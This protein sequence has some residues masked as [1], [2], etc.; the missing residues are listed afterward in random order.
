MVG[1]P[2]QIDIREAIPED[3]VAIVELMLQA[4]G[5][6]LQFILDELEP[7][8]SAS[9]L[10]RHMITSIDSECSYRRCWVAVMPSGAHA[11]VVGMVN[12]FPA[13]LLCAQG[14]PSNLT[15]REVHLWPRTAL[16]EPDSYC[17]NSLAVFPLYRRCGIAGRLIDHAAKQALANG[18]ST[19]SL[20]VWEDNLPALNLYR[21][22]GFDVIGRAAIARHP[23]LPYSGDSLLMGLD[24]L[25]ARTSSSLQRGTAILAEVDDECA[26]ISAH[27]AQI[28]KS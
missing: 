23:E 20:H 5:D 26:P 11:P 14:M 8:V 22:S 12:A 21:R 6:T 25:R 17:I 3:V 4:A 27:I 24:D 9:D 28:G 16:Q 2:V 19:L 1:P 18:F 10:F 7:R 15:A 13:A